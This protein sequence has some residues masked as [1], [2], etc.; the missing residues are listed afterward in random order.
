MDM[1]L[2]HPSDATQG[3]RDGGGHGGHGM[4]GH[5]GGGGDLP[6]GKA[7]DP[8]CGMTVDIETAKG[9]GLHFNYKGR[10]YYFCGKGCRLDFEEEPERI[11]DP[12]YLPSM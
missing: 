5:G 12:K 11:L 9:K 10:D 1:H 3:G 2:G 4:G 7:L 6:A 8:V